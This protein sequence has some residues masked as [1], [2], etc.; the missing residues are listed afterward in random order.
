MHIFNDDGTCNVQM[1]EYAQECLDAFPEHVGKSCSTSSK[2]D[3][4]T[5]CKRRSLPKHYDE[6]DV[7]SPKMQSRSPNKFGVLVYQSG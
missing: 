4:F 1:D 2:V 6:S 7:L 5:S 3:L